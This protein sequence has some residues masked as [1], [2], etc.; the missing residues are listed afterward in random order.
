MAV[1]P[2]L[3]LGAGAADERIVLRHRAVGRD[4]DH[5]AEMVAEVLRLVAVGEVLAQR[6]EQ[7]A[8]VGLRDAAAEVIAATTAGPA[9]GRSS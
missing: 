3:R 6:D 2:D 4:P 9:G 7:I 5:L 1:A 8:V